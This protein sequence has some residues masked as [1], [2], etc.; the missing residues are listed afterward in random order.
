MRRPLALALAACL[1]VAPGGAALADHDDW[2]E[3]VS[4]IGTPKYGDDFR[5][6]DYVNPDAPKGGTLNQVSVG[7]FDSFN[8]FIVRGTVAAGLTPTGG[9][10]YD[11]LMDQATDQA[12]TSY[13][14]IA[15]AVRYPADFSSA[16]IRL[17]PDARWHD[18][19][20]I[21]ADDVVWTFGVLKG[22]S[23]FWNQYYNHIEKAEKTAADEVTFTFD[24]AR[25]R[26]LPNI[27]G[28]MPVLPRHWWEGTGANG[29]KRDITQPTL[30]PPLGSGPY[31]I[32][33]FEGGRSI[34]WQRVADYWGA[35]E[36]T[37]VGR[38]NFDQ[39]K[40]VYF[41]NVDAV[42]EAFKKGGLYDFRMENRAQRWAQGYDFPAF[43]RGDVKKHTY[44]QEA[45]EPM[46]AFVFNTRRAKFQ[47]PRVRRALT[48]AFD[49]ES[50]NRT[51][52]YGLYKRT[53]SYFEGTELASS[54]LP[55]GKELEILETVR[56]EVPPELFTEP[57]TLPV[58]EKPGDERTYL[59]QAS[60]LLREAG[61]TPQGGRLVNEATGEAMSIE[62]LGND[63]TDERVMLPYVNA[64]RRLGIDARIRLVD[65]AQYQ[66]LTDNFDFDVVVD[67]FAQSQSPGNEQREFWGSQAADQPGSRNA[68]GIKNPAVDKL[69]DRVIYARDREELVAAT[70]ALDRVLLWNY[71]MVPQWHNPEVWIAYWDKFGI[72][73][74]QPAYIGVDT[75]SWWVDQNRES[76]V[77]VEK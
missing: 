38:Y 62:F 31:K 64:L 9:L 11:T 1:L 74:K 18:G 67:I 56:D 66:A 2:H 50:M 12:G 8:P 42:W 19:Q 15:E 3:A 13:G 76:R 39:V 69:I 72:P 37:R 20:P 47:D 65:T 29:R 34:T 4:L 43:Q 58:Y 14:L 10:L 48:L 70:H 63:P 35:D 75:F 52:F 59:R 73:E 45:G 68:A 23:P 30:E 22:T 54:G 51:L 17:N 71:Y 7:T 41:R 26:E 33:A 40:Y 25:N 36:P 49:F 57:F 77:E 61:W 32:G 60:Q 55:Q 44:L 16:T 27:I 5:H 24:Q 53:D 46:Q 21:T 6:Y 28:D